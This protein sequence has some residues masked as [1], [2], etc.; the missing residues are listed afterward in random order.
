MNNIVT[1]LL[2]FN[3]IPGSSINKDIREELKC[4]FLRK[5]YAYPIGLD[6][7]LDMSGSVK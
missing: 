6:V 5:E 3:L 1:Y 4:E 2:K 7:G